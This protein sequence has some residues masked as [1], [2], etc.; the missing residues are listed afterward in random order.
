MSLRA[1]LDGCLVACGLAAMLSLC[2]QGCHAEVRV[3]DR[4]APAVAADSAPAPAAVTAADVDAALAVQRAAMQTQ[5]VVVDGVEVQAPPGSTV[6]VTREGVRSAK[7]D[8]ASLT[9][10][11]K[12]IVTGFDSSAPT[13]EIGA[14]GATKASG[15]GSSIDAKIVGATGAGL[16]VL[17]GVAGGLCLLGAGVAA[18]LR[19]AK[20]AVYAGLA[21]GVLLALAFFPSLVL[22][23]LLVVAGVAALVWA[24]HRG[25]LHRE[26]LRA[27]V[28][29]IESIPDKGD[30]ELVKRAVA[31]QADDR[32]RRTITAVKRADGFGSER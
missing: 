13:G 23:G 14:D 8:G 10:A 27:V 28:G 17:L 15:G 1:V 32:D 4:P 11:G 6:E 22:C 12:D 5:R 21:G 16:R 9:A 7:G 19:L 2:W 30:R 31:G 20:A 26:A 25:L 18:Y 29:G 3:S 24:D